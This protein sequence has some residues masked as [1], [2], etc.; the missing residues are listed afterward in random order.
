MERNIVQEKNQFEELIQGLINDNYGC[1]NDFLSLSA[2]LGLR[3][4][5]VILNDSGKMMQLEKI[6][7]IGFR[8]KV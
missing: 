8:N 4:N 1:C 6:K 7:L 3:E 5:M 2:M